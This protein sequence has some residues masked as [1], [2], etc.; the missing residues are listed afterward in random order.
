MENTEEFGVAEVAVKEAK[1]ATLYEAA[2]M[3][4]SCTS[5]EQAFNQLKQM[6]DSL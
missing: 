2:I 1:K 3:I 5:V 6:A 4:Q